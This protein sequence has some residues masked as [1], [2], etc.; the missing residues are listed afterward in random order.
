MCKKLIYLICLSLVLGLANNVSAGLVAHWK[1]DEGSGTTVSDASGKGNDGTLQGG[2]TVVEGQSGQSLAFANSRVAIPAS[3]SL[4]AGLFQGSFT[5]AAWINP[6]RTGNT[7]QQ[8][9]RSIKVDGTSNDTLFLNN[10]GRL[11][12][13]G[14]VGGTWTTLCETAAGV[15]PANQWTHVAVTGDGTNFRIYVNA[16]LSQQ[17]AFQKTDGTNA[18]YYIGGDPGTAGESYAGM[19]D[20]MRVYNHVLSETEIRKLAARPKAR[21]PSP[22]DGAIVADTW[23][24]LGWSPGDYAVSHDLYLG[25]SFADV[26]S[27]AAGVFRGN[28][29]ST[30]F[31][32]GLG[33]PGDPYPGG[34]VPGTTYYWRVDEVNQADP[35]SPWKGPVWSFSIPPRKAYEPSP[36]DGA[37]YQDLGVALKWTPGLGA[38]LHYV[39]FGDNLDTV[40]NA[41][42]G[43]PL[44][45]ASYTPT[46]PL[47]L[48]KTYYWRVDEFDGAA[49]YKGD[50]WSFTTTIPGLGTAVM[51]RWEN[52]SGTALSGLKSDPRYP[53]NPTV[54]E[55]VTRFAWD[56]PDTDNYGARIYGWLYIPVTGDYT[57]WLNTDDNGELWLSTDDDA[58]NIR[59]IARETGYT[60]LNVWNTGEEQSQPI[61]LVGGEKYYIEALWKEGTGGDHCQVAWQGPGIATRTIIPGT[62]LSPYEPLSAHGAKPANGATGV[63]D[64]PLLQWKAGL[65][66]ASHEVYFGT[67]PNAVK[68][69]TKTSPEYKGTRMLG[70][71]S[72]TPTMLDW[73]ATYYWRIDEVNNANPGSPWVGKV[74]SFTTADFGIVE[75]FEAYNDVAAG[76]AGSNLVYLTWLDGFGTTTNGSTMGYPTGSSLETARVHGGTKAVPL[77]YNNSPASFSEAERTF[78]PQNWTNYG[79]QTLSLWFYGDPA[80]VAGRLYVKVNGVKAPYNGE[81]VNLTRQQWQIWNVDL[82][83]V[84]TN[85]QSVTKLAVGI[86]G[87]GAKGTLLLDD[88]RL[89]ALPRQ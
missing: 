45:T 27:G 47:A 52:I 29:A 67:E 83:S 60:S 58:A 21:I 26:N 85:L 51:E 35:N 40:S 7:W 57:F 42:A 49:T 25:E 63:S 82:A 16:A 70:S 71:E 77:I 55:T 50:I 46:G 14:R 1:L 66:A 54:T 48:D 62:S 32:I 36:G 24:N 10:D 18:T 84:G 31:F 68:N 6:K 59:I 34:L 20:D 78:A 81:A 17:S 8:I 4:T 89:Y 80:N 75:D 53:A 23:V 44:G 43:L 9:F 61:S 56:G 69:A 65:A 22:A 37:K 76:Q 11:S 88:I 73:E 74:W 39:Y 5:L 38:K 86:E 72:Y 30:M 87:T 33:L 41:T 15:V 28:Q 64:N 12:W 13:R 2:P 19:V 3:N 79:I